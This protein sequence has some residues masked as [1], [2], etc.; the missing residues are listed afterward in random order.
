MPWIPLTIFYWRTRV[1]KH[2]ESFILAHH[3]IPVHRLVINESR[4][5]NSQTCFCL[6]DEMQS[7]HL[8]WDGNH[9]LFLMSCVTN[10]LLI[11]A[12]LST[13]SCSACNMLLSQVDVTC[14]WGWRKRST[15]RRTR[16]KRRS[17][18]SCLPHI[19]MN[20]SSEES[21]KSMSSNF[22]II[23]DWLILNR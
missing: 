5:Q 11:I 13:E 9:C 4:D 12:Y 19:E 2:S 8:L 3:C 15:R 18:S 7:V 16:R 21:Q 23:F 22:V 20:P 17:N 6:S 14:T 10:L 1:D